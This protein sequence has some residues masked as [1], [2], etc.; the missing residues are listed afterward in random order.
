MAKER[1][2]LFRVRP[3]TTVTDNITSPD[4]LINLINT[5]ENML[6]AGL[7]AALKGA[8]GKESLFQTWMY[9][10]NENIQSAGKTYGERIIAEEFKRVVDETEVETRGIGFLFIG[11]LSICVSLNTKRTVV[12]LRMVLNHFS[13]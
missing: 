6:F 9:E 4:Q 3:T 11:S 5:R 1:L 10:E 8:K 13:Y 12:I 2:G 7:G